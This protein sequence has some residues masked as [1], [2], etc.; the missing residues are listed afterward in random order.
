M[1]QLTRSCASLPDCCIQEMAPAVN[2]SMARTCFKDP[3][4][5]GWACNRWDGRVTREELAVVDDWRLMGAA[6]AALVR[7]IAFCLLIVVWLW[8]LDRLQ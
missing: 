6:I 8:P 1:L 5:C 3:D 4:R 7:S 2:A